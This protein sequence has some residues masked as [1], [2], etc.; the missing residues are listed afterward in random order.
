MNPVRLTVEPVPTW[1]DAARLLA[2]ASL[3]ACERVPL[4]ATH[5]RLVLSLPATQA[6]DLA[7]RLRG[8]GLDGAPLSVTS[9][10]P[11]SRG[12]V[13][14]ARL[15][16]ARLR[17]ETT[18]GFLRPGA[19]AT[20]EGRFSLTPEALAVELGQLARAAGALH[21]LDA[22]CGS[23]GNAIGFAR[24]G[25]TVTA[26]ELD[27]PRLS[28]ARHNAALYGVQR[29]IEFVHADARQV[30]PTRTADLLFIDPPWG[31]QYDKRASGRGDVPLL[32]ELLPVQRA[33]YPQVWLKLPGSFRLASSAGL[34]ERASASAWFG[35]A[36]GDAQ[37]IKFVLLQQGV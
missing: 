6:A 22:C 25:C 7:A 29:G 30:V 2:P 20:G 26:V 11:L 33:A 18:P 32:A 35:T 24:A 3:S 5:E 17:R 36:K 14:E 34:L 4:D 37:R 31:E 15:R 23:G 21:V 1:L 13:R 28:E 27:G 12:L 10:P 16:D 8:L 9:E 19:R